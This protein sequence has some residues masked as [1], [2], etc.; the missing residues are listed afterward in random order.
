MD[1]ITPTR[2]AF[3]LHLII[4]AASV[5]FPKSVSDLSPSSRIRMAA[6]GPWNN[7]LTWFL[8][9]VIAGTKLSNLFYHDYTPQGRVV[10]G[11]QSTSALRG[12][13][14]SGSIVEFLDDTPLSGAEDV[15]GPFLLTPPE[16]TEL[17]ETRGWCIDRKRYLASTASPCP[18]GVNMVEFTSLP[19]N[20][21]VIGATA[22]DKE[23]SRSRGNGKGKSQ[24]KEDKSI[25]RCLPAYPLLTSRTWS[26][27]CSSASQVCVRPI[28]E[29]KILRIQWRDPDGSGVGGGTEGKEEEG[30]VVVLWSG[31]RREVW[32]VVRV[33]RWAGRGGTG[34]RW[35][36]G[37]LE[38]VYK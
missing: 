1:T 10:L 19:L 17:D 6:S 29:E 35:V 31:E 26:C 38:L 15:W 34:G 37:W 9:T 12:H 5:T 11:I 33:S 24:G 4:P 2:L 32:D 28:L 36:V 13:I 20:S 8:F 7:L 3:N 18:E 16:R 23:R 25:K 30:P 27:P 14:P 21:S 22:A